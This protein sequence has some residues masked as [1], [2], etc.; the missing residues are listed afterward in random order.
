[1]RKREG[2]S[3]RSRPKIRKTEHPAAIM[4]EKLIQKLTSN[5]CQIGP[6]GAHRSL[7]SNYTHTTHAFKS[8]TQVFSKILNILQANVEAYDPMAIIGTILVALKVVGHRKARDTGPAVPN[9]KKLQ[10]VHKS[11]H[12]FFCKFLPENDGENACGTHEIPFPEFMSWTRREGGMQHNFH[13][14]TF[15]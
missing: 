4:G 11:Q 5:S 9:L 1:M 8:P 3:L 10:I 14:L 15:R 2:N 13:F 7:I 12:L 6:L